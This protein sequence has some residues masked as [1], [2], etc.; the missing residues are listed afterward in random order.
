VELKESS[1]IFADSW[2]GQHFRGM[3]ADCVCCQHSWCQRTEGSRG[4]SLFPPWQ[5][6]NL[7]DGPRRVLRKA[8]RFTVDGAILKDRK[9]DYWCAVAVVLGC[10]ASPGAEAAVRE[11]RRWPRMS[12]RR[13]VSVAALMI[14]MSALA[15]VS[16][17]CGDSAPAEP[18]ARGGEWVGE[19]ELGTFTMIV[20]MSGETITHMEAEWTCD[21][22][23]LSTDLELSAPIGE[24]GRF[25]FEAPAQALPPPGLR[26]EGRFEKGTEEKTQTDSG[27]RISKS[28]RA[29]GVW[30]VPGA[31]GVSCSSDW[32]ITKP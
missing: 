11:A 10:G 29:V 27:V 3:R 26:L 14:L 15:G 21:G 16:A 7:K 19:T 6:V 20:D 17:S 9:T 8:R 13:L 1:L 30:R 28:I 4:S 32:E 25:A 23:D 5:E 18:L 12:V 31:E 24:D 2:D 22:R